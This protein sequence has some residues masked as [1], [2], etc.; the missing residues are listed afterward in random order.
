MIELKPTILSLVEFAPAGGDK[1][2][3]AVTIDPKKDVNIYETLCLYCAD[4]NFSL[5]DVT[6]YEFNEA[7][8]LIE[9]MADNS[10]SEFHFW[11]NDRNI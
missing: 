4:N 10:E 3:K 8:E 6:N 11:L 2:S 7:V 1:P 5:D 9:N